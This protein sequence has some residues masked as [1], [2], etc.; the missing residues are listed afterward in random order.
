M[1]TD[2][3]PSADVDRL[4]ETIAEQQRLIEMQTAQNLA[5]L[6]VPKKMGEGVLRSTVFQH[7]FHLHMGVDVL[8]LLCSI[9]MRLMLS[10]HDPL[11]VTVEVII[12]LTIIFGV[13]RFLV[14]QYED[15]EKA[16][17][18][19][20]IVLTVVILVF[21]IFSVVLFVYV[22]PFVDT[23]N[24]WEMWGTM[25]FVWFAHV[26]VMH[27]VL[28]LLVSTHSFS[29]PHI[30]RWGGLSQAF[31]TVSTTYFAN[32][33]RTEKHNF[34]FICAC[35]VP[36]QCGFWMAIC[37][38]A[39]ILA[40]YR[41]YIDEATECAQAPGPCRPMTMQCSRSCMLAPRACGA[42]CAARCSRDASSSSRGRRSAWTTTASS[43]RS[44]PGGNKQKR[45]IRKASAARNAQACQ[46]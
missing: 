42:G 15:Q 37:I 9:N 26:P 3:K 34:F 2:T 46:R 24:P 41:K 35:Q 16:A 27:T 18:W 43:Y 4:L 17:R 23:T 14:H 11:N 33:F 13:V 30:H 6:T 39:Q 5:T 20:A 31:M 7:C 44:S 8:L 45:R 21:S 28:G 38:G 25:C 1:A 40:G 12:V 36:Q 29:L 32:Q 22:R 10:S 19:S